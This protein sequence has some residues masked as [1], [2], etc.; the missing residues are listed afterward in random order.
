MLYDGIVELYKTFRLNHYRSLFSKIR[1]RDGSLSATEAFAVDV[2]YLLGR[3]TLGEFAACLGLSQPNATYK[4]NNLIAKGYVIKTPS[5]TDR[6]ECILEVTDRFF[7]Y[8]GTQNDFIG[9]AVKTLEAEFSNDELQ[10][11]E[12]VLERFNRSA[13]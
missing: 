3:P 2:I 12:R 5:E 9:E 6:R 7:S 4:V 1:E 11:L 8:Y 13:E 10:L